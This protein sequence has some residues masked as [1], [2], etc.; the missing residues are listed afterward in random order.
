VKK[1]Q[2]SFHFLRVL[3][4]NSLEEKLLVSF[5]RAT[6][7]SI[8][9]YCITVRYAGC[10]AADRRALQG[11]INTAQ[12][13]TGCSLPALDNIASSRFA[14]RATHIVQD[15]SHPS[16]HFLNQLPSGRRYRSHKARTNRLRDSFFP[17]AIS[18]LS[19]L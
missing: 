13:I 1:A 17:R 14:S 10:T 18:N 4:R 3:R 16:H 9:A 11:V 2:Q 8:P 15:S 6:V 5:Y 12:R 7:E 19:K